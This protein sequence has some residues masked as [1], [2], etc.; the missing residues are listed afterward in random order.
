MLK[1]KRIVIVNN[2]SESVPPPND[3]EDAAEPAP[4]SAEHGTTP[5][6]PDKLTVPAS[7]TVTYELE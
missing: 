6:K 5:V 4:S 1:I 3:S 7:V 2:V